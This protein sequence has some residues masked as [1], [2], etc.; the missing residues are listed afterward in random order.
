MARPMSTSQNVQYRYKALPPINSQQQQQRQQRNRNIPSS[1]KSDQL[2][3]NQR[4][5]SRFIKHIK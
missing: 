2:F 3:E 5:I 1:N 4:R